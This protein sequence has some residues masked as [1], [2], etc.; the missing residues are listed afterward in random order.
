MAKKEK[1]VCVQHET[2]EEVFVQ[3]ETQDSAKTIVLVAKNG[4]TA[5]T[6]SPET[7]IAQGWEVVREVTKD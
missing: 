1:Q 6:A 3:H 2:Q 7:W 5:E 4:L